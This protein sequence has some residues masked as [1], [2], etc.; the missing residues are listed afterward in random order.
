MQKPDYEI[1]CKTVG[2]L[3]FFGMGDG[4]EQQRCQEELFGQRS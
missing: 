4:E 1:P 3:H 2:E